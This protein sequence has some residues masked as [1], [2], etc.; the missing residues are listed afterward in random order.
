MVI[1]SRISMENKE[2][3]KNKLE[4]FVKKIEDRTNSALDDSLMDED[5]KDENFNIKYTDIVQNSKK[6]KMSKVPWLTA[7]FLILICAIFIG[8]RF[9]GNNPQTIFTQTVDGLFNYLSDNLNDNVYDITDG[10]IDLSYNINGSDEIYNELSKVNWDIDYVRDNANNMTYALIKTKYDNNDFLKATLYGDGKNTYI[11]SSTIYDN[12][13]KLSDNKLGTI[14][15]SSDIKVLLEGVNQAID[16]V[17]SNEKVTSGKEDNNTYVKLNVNKANRDRVVETFINTLKSNDEFVSVLA[18]IKDLKTSEVKQKLDNYI[19][20]IKRKVKKQDSV[21]ITLYTNKKNEFIKGSIVGKTSNLTLTK[22]NSLFTY[23]ITYEND[24]ISGTF[25]FKVNDSKTKYNI[26]LAYKYEKDSKI[27]IDSSYTL[28]F[29]T[30]KAENFKK[31][32]LDNAIDYDDMNLGQKFELYTKMVS[33]PNL[34]K[35]MPFIQK[36]L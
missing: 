15:N 31:V 16:K 2:P 1:E 10:N 32:K 9:F 19:I 8:I 11:K 26:N 20:K 12:Y 30:K 22:D 34:D 4:D 36:I 7:I 5:A 6:A 27:I 18:K 25:D 23:D 24:H 35:L 13:I 33:I 29:T 21:D 28:K 17:I 14:T 3:L